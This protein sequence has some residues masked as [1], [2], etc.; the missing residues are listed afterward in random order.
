[1]T[2]AGYPFSLLVLPETLYLL[3]SNAANVRTESSPAA[4]EA[5]GKSK[6]SIAVGGGTV[7]AYVISDDISSASVLGI[8]PFVYMCL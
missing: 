8:L 5:A 3:W 4:S 6:H 2:L 7:R 1:M